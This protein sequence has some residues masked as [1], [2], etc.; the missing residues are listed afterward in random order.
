MRGAFAGGGRAAH[1]VSIAYS[2]NGDADVKIA[3]VAMMQD[4]GGNWF[5]VELPM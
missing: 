3:E 1:T 5:V 4:G 2:L